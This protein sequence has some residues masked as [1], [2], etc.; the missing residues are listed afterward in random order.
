MQD[1]TQVQG[2]DIVKDTM[3]R[4]VKRVENGMVKAVAIV[5]CEG[6]SADIMLAG[7]NSASGG[8][9]LGCDMIKQL[10][11]KQNLNVFDPLRTEQT[12]ANVVCYDLAGYPICFDFV[13]WLATCEMLRRNE[14]I[15]ASLVVGFAGEIRNDVEGDK[16]RFLEGV[17]RPALVLFGAAEDAA[18]APLVGR[19]VSYTVLRDAA[20][21]FEGGQPVP[22]IAV[23]RGTMARVKDALGPRQPVT[24]TLRETEHHKHRN[25]NV[26]SWM[27]FGHWLQDQ[28][29]RV[30][31]LRDTAKAEEMFG[32]LETMPQ[33]SRDLH[34]RAALY[35]QAKVNFFVCNGPWALACF[36]TAPW[37][38]FATVTTGES[39][40]VQQP[41]FWDAYMGLN[42]QRQLPWALPSQR[43]VYE[44]DTFENLKRAWERLW[45]RPVQE[46]AE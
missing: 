40:T 23:P 3:A 34:V 42:A 10:I 5:F 6:A 41:E 38:L 19:R 12:P 35:E 31:V 37:V 22:R 28:G 9:N 1:F 21:I 8:I 11:I 25:S 18:A 43:I 17:M 4:A 20:K 30:I 44:P 2:N 45:E 39:H 24:L 36:G 16:R 7:D 14:G 26:E 32:N 29:E 15:Q 13:L 33:A 46:A 27:R